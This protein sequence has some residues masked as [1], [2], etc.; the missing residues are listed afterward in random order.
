MRK[1]RIV[2]LAAASCALFSTPVLAGTTL[3]FNVFVPHRFFMY[4]V[5]VQWGKDVAHAT[6]GRVTVQIPEA[7][8][9][10]PPGQWNAVRG[11]VVDGAFIFNSFAPDQVKKLNTFGQLPFLGGSDLAAA[12]VAYWRTY[13][14]YFAG[15][16]ATPGVKVVGVF[17]APGGQM[18]SLTDKPIDTLAEL[19]AHKMWALPGAPAELMKRLGVP[20]VSGPSVR[21]Q[22]LFSRHVVEGAI[23]SSADAMVSFQGA[24][25]VKSSTLFAQGVDMPSF[26]A[27]ISQSKWNALGKADQAAVMSV[28]G[29][30][31][32]RAMG[33]AGAA[34]DARAHAVMEKNGVAFRHASPALEAVFQRPAAAIRHDWVQQARSA[35]V[36]G[37]AALAYFRAQLKQVQAR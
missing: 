29:E 15:H 9:A 34:A 24:P 23:G 31:L 37:Q 11:G 16:E 25:Y 32:A 18:Y 17:L 13:V 20:F 7:S 12:A 21:Q 14:K 27:F 36:D 4:P 28:S 6:H 1:L 22:E 5:F 8:V 33:E 19:K 26:T 3:L 2:A 10:P 30:A 35:G